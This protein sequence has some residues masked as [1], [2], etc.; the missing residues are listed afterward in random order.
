MTSAHNIAD[1]SL[2]IVGVKIQNK[3]HDICVNPLKNSK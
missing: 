1:A 3:L 2:T